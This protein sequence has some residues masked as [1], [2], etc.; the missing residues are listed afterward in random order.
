[1]SIDTRKEHQAMSDLDHGISRRDL[2][3]GAGAVASAVM[4]GSAFAAPET[5]MPVGAQKMEHHYSHAQANKKHKALAAAA[6]E[7]TAK[8]EACISHCLETF[9][10][11]DTTMAEC[12]NA[13]QQMLPVCAAMSQLSMYDSKHLPALAQACVGVCEDCEK[14][15]RAHEEHQPECRECADAC[16][17]LIKEAKKILA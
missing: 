3:L 5:G 2:L 7:C 4:A 8:G 6:N 12:A 15:C 13:V 1:M 11:G 14:E 17:A 16:A 10:S 9:L